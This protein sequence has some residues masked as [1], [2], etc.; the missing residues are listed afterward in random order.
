LRLQLGIFLLEELLWYLEENSNHLFRKLSGG[1]LD[2]RGEFEP[3]LA[4]V[5]GGSPKA[6]VRAATASM[7]A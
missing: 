5:A 1:W 6:I 3:A 4:A 7:R 2:F